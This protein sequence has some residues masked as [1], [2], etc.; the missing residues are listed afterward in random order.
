MRKLI[1]KNF[2]YGGF[3]HKRIKSI[4]IVSLTI[5][6][7]LLTKLVAVAQLKKSERESAEVSTAF[8]KG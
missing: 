5:V 4:R 2:L 7:D 8:S 6:A 3:I 1:T